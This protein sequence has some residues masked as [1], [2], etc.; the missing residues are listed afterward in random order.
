MKQ[1]ENMTKQPPKDEKVAYFFWQ[2]KRASK[3]DLG[4]SALKVVDLDLEG[5]KQMRV[6]ESEE[7]AAFLR[8][9]KGHMLVQSSAVLER[10]PSKYD[11]LS[12]NERSN[13]PYGHVNF[14][15]FFF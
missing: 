15:L 10:N 3:L 11:K 8:L 12:V 14:L 9:F 2:G 5:G 4:T 13:E 1:R 7:P 6:A